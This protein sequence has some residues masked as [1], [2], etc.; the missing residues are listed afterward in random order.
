MIMRLSYTN[1]E[2]F[3]GTKTWENKTLYNIAA[4]GSFA[5]PK[6]YNDFIVYPVEQWELNSFLKDVIVKK[7]CKIFRYET[8]TSKI[9]GFAPVIEIN[10]VSG[11]VY[12]NNGSEDVAFETKSA[13]PTYINLNINQK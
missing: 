1:L 4:V 9:G 5:L 12:F 2:T 13:K 10:M 3:K 6:V 8:E 7:D 11:L